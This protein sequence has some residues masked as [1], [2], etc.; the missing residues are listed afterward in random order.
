MLWL[1]LS[2]TSDYLETQRVVKSNGYT[3]VEYEE[4]FYKDHLYIVQVW[5]H[6]YKAHAYGA[7]QQ[8]HVVIL[9]G[10]VGTVCR[11][12]AAMTDYC[13]KS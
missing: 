11:K 3:I 9:Q 13:N 8:W 5:Q 7:T 4:Y 10:T 6:V 12:H 1:D 2:Y